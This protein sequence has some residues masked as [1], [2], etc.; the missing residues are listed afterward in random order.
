MIHNE[1]AVT[2]V[3]AS[4]WLESALT[5]GFPPP[6]HLF[7]HIVLQLLI[8]KYISLNGSFPAFT[9]TAALRTFL[10]KAGAVESQGEEN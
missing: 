4:F 8:Y 10:M 1:L 2:V 6:H 7:L 3:Q 5:Q 9:C